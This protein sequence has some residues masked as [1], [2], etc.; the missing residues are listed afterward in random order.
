MAIR[1][2]IRE[3]EMNDLEDFL[4]HSFEDIERVGDAA[5]FVLVDVDGFRYRITVEHLS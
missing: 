2:A 3:A 4:N 5:R 1:Q